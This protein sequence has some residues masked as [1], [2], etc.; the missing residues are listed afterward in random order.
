VLIFV[1][2][3]SR[4]KSFHQALCFIR[5]SVK[6]IKIALKNIYSSFIHYFILVV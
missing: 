4:D 1:G 5:H 3:G 2:L 6:M